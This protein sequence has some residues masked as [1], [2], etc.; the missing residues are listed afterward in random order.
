M[1]RIVRWIK[2][3][4]LLNLTQNSFGQQYFYNEKYYD[5]D[6]LIEAGLSSGFMNAFTDLGGRKG[7]GAP[8]LKDLQLKNSKAFAGLEI[9]ALYNYQ[10]GITIQYTHGSV[11]A[12]DSVLKNEKGP[13]QS[14]YLR[15]LHFRSVIRELTL[16]LEWHFW[17]TFQDLNN[18]SPYLSAGIG[19]FQ[20]R[21][22]ASLGQQWFDLQPL[23][24]EGQGFAEYSDQ[25]VY[26]LQQFNLPLGIG[27]QYEASALLHFKLELI[28]RILFTDYLDDV[29]KNYID[30]RLY[31][32]YLSPE[33]AALAGLLADRRKEV[34]PGF[35][36]QVG[37]KRGN[38]GKNDSYFTINL[39]M[40]LVLNRKRR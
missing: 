34:E 3:L 24:T 1:E 39:K 16:G 29:S 31:A 37:D 8:F 30:P 28:S 4:I 15:N 35:I 27:L 25:S 33:Q 32:K 6:W 36:R 17:R 22:K 38:P 5:N 14:R 20:F 40:N 9:S 21:P 7:K 11:S 12:Q 19:Y 23:R 26:S 18:L 10:F 2:L 13:E